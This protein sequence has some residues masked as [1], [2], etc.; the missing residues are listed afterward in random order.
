MAKQ[1][2][3][4]GEIVIYKS[5]TGPEIEVKLERETV[6]LTQKQMAT[7]FDKVELKPCSTIRNFRIV[8]RK[9]QR[10]I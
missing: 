2:F 6:W 1:E 9:G 4:K 5:P 7:L 3:N 8:Q 10:T